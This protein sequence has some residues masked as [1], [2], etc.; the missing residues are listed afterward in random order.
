MHQTKKYL[1]FQHILHSSNSSL[2]S[3]DL[4][5]RMQPWFLVY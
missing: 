1:P 2:I 4:A 5:I 3:S